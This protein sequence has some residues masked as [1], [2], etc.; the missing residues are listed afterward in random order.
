MYLINVQD[1]NGEVRMMLDTLREF[2]RGVHP[3]DAAASVLTGASRACTGFCLGATSTQYKDIAEEKLA[4]GLA[5]PA[6]D[7]R[8]PA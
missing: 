4:C 5:L 6:V 2:L 1:P 3:D 8:V 7:G